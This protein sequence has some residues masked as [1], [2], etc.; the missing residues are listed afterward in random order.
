[1]VLSDFLVISRFIVAIQPEYWM[2]RLDAG[3]L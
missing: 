1:L 2:V 3:V